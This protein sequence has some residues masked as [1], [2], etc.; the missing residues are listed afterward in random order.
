MVKSLMHPSPAKLA[1]DEMI[2]CTFFFFLSGFSFTGTGNSQDSRGRRG[3]F[4]IPLYH[5][6][7]F[8]NIQTFM[9]NFAHEM[10]ITYF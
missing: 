10:T 1:E 7:P 6:H 4:F 9:G 5:F 2:G 3:P 8:T